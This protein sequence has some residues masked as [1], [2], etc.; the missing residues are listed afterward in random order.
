M[1]IEKLDEGESALYRGLMHAEAGHFL[2]FVELALDVRKE[3]AVRARWDELTT[4]EADVL[5]AQA[6]G[7]RIHSGEP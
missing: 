1:R 7:P 4:W 5:A 6:P 3:S 2:V